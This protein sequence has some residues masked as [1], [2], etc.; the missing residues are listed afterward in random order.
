MPL[1]CQNSPCAQVFG[2]V[3]RGVLHLS[4][5]H[6]STLEQNLWTRRGT[7]FPTV[8]RSLVTEQA[9]TQSD[10]VELKFSM[11]SQLPFIRPSLYCD[12][13]PWF[14]TAAFHAVRP[15]TRA[16]RGPWFS[17]NRTHLIKP[18]TPLGIPCEEV[19]V[20]KVRG[21]CEV[22]KTH[23][24]WV[25]DPYHLVFHLLRI[26]CFK[27]TQNYWQ[28]TLEGRS[29][30]CRKGSCWSCWGTWSTGAAI[31]LAAQEANHP[32]RHCWGQGLLN[33]KNWQNQAMVLPCFANL[34]LF[35]LINTWWLFLF[36]SKFPY[37]LGVEWWELNLLHRTMPRPCPWK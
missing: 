18:D 9:C 3:P 5:A 14:S 17:L 4:G 36:L 15:G 22:R 25:V 13:A 33:G 32:P 28:W 35:F 11:R 21:H 7:I 19:F 27:K 12:S 30:D 26:P 2:Q 10:V 31:T 34:T 20:G 23:P 24:V 16:Q 1:L 6:W 29:A 8:N 37:V